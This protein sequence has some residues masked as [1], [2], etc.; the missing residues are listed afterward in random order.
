M[1]KTLLL[2]PLVAGV[3]FLLMLN[4][5][6][7]MEASEMKSEVGITF[8]SSALDSSLPNTGRKLP[9][10]NGNLPTTGEILNYSFIFLGILI[11]VLVL[12]FFWKKTKQKKEE[13]KT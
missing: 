4:P 9:N 2:S 11:L 1:K 8:V 5:I 6:S 13:T 10:T 3:Y 7:V 12:Y